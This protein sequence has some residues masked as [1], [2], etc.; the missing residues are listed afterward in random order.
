MRLI[1]YPTTAAKPLIRPARLERSWMDAT[2][3]KNAYRCLP[4]AMANSHGWEI[5][6]PY[7]MTAEW[8]GGPRRD[9]VAVW[10]VGHLETGRIYSHFGAGVLTFDPACMLRTEARVNLWV[11]GPANDPK[12]GIAPLSG[13]VETDWAPYSFTM[14]WRFTRPGRVTFRKGEPFC[15]FFPVMRAVVDE[16]APEIRPMSSDP[17]LEA[18]YKQWT[19]SRTDFI[20]EAEQPG[21][22]ASKQGWQKRYMRGLLPD[23]SAAAA[24]QTRV[25]ARPFVDGE[26]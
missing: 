24:H 4:L 6:A 22:E 3:D 12:D 9:D 11:T 10:S 21:T 16:T 15:F 2:A 25:R 7:A 8:N 13:V 23:G 18:A 5:L 14:N 26:G 19:A 1:C 17:D 20:R